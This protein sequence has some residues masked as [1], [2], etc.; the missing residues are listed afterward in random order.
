MTRQLFFSLFLCTCFS[1]SG[2][3]L[4]PE[5]AFPEEVV[6][7]VQKNAQP[8]SS[9]VPASFREDL[10][11][12]EQIIGNH[13]LV[14]LGEG[15]H[16]TREIFQIKDKIVRYLI[17]Q[18]GFSTLGIEYDLIDGVYVNRYIHDQTEDLYHALDQ[19]RGWVWNTEE[20]ATFIQWLA[21]NNARGE[22][23]DYYGI[24]LFELVRSAHS[25]LEYLRKN[26]VN[27]TLFSEAWQASFG[28]SLSF[29]A[30]DTDSFYTAL[31]EA[32]LEGN[33]R[34]VELMQWIADEF[35]SIKNGA[36]S[37]TSDWRFHQQL[38]R[39]ALNRSRHL[40][41]FNYDYIFGTDHWQEQLAL[42]RAFP[43]KADSLRQYLSK[44]S[45][46]HLSLTIGPILATVENPFRGRT[47]YLTELDFQQRRDWSD[48]IQLAIQRLDLR[49]EIYR[50]KMTDTDYQHFLQLLGDLDQLLVWYKN[51][52]DQPL[53]RLNYREVGLADNVRFLDSLKNSGTVIWAHN[54]HVTKVQTNTK[55]DGDK[56]GTFLKQ[57]YGDDMLVIG[58]LIGQGTVQAW[59]YRGEKR[60]LGVMQIPQPHAGTMEDL[61]VEA[62]CTICL[63]D[64]RQI[65]KDG[66]V[67]DW[68][69]TEQS[70]RSVGNF[71]N[72]DEPEDF[73]IKDVIPDHF[74]VLVF[75][76]ETNRA[77]PTE[78]VRE[79][80]FKE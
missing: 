17:D 66:V 38:A 28:Q 35:S 75:I 78:A 56:M 45:D 52:F 19:Q 12:L 61:F 33:Y 36:R 79:R 60:K 20:L 67:A 72:P 63:L 26:E 21:G 24:D 3:E 43:Q 11:C 34:L 2:Q 5:A 69:G 18:K 25:A 50:K 4:K 1:T 31:D 16:G 51:A 68:F 55:S 39:T 57:V 58:T 54:L 64:L 48:N 8:I 9:T 29:Y 47:T 22:G 70:F 14:L 23:V 74:D 62:D 37:D 32:G 13:Q 73:F 65:P 30:S 27:P 6:S 41:Q 40:L 59:D 15:T 49:R 77:V 53:E 10:S 46:A 42:F 44:T 7:W 76:R 80:Y 71:Y